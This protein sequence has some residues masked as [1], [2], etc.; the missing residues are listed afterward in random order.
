MNVKVGGIYFNHLASKS[1]LEIFVAASLPPR[2]I[3]RLTPYKL[4]SSCLYCSLN[5]RITSDVHTGSLG[6]S[7]KDYWH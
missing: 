4:G 7:L 3:L 2:N 5:A 1:Y 6:N